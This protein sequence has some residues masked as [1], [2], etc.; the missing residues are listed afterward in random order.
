M[1]LKGSIQGKKQD[2]LIVC[3]PLP[4]IN[5]SYT[6]KNDV[7]KIYSVCGKSGVE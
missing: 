5:N 2:I 1:S 3:K 4:T 6:L 7:Y